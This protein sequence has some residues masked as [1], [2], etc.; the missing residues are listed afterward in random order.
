MAQKD[1]HTERLDLE[2]LA[3]AHLEHE[4][5][6]DADPEVM[7][8]LWGRARTRA[9]VEADHRRRLARSRHV[10]GLGLWAGLL[11]G[12]QPGFV[13]LWMLPPTF[14][15][16]GA[17][18]PGEAELGYRVLRSFWRRGLAREGS[19]ELLRH[20]FD[21]LALERVV[22]RTMAVNAASR[23]TMTS[24]GMRFV[25]GYHEEFDEPLPGS[26]HG[27]VEYELLAS[28]WRAAGR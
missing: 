11:C 19:L 16:D 25:R 18:V 1:L 6:L 10:G 2:P 4:V 7:R 21:D 12:V 17:P 27:E 24:L 15:A 22:A 14:T 13:G 8:H 26:E 5:R 9:E 20:G 3:D 23:A 28:D